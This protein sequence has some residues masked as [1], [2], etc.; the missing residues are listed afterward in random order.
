MA[1]LTTV[2]GHPCRLFSPCAYKPDQCKDC[3]E[4]KS[5]HFGESRILQ[6]IDRIPLEDINTNCE[7]TEGIE[8]LKNAFILSS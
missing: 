4:S 5:S 2:S 8:K 1:Q 3:F 7:Y 6:E